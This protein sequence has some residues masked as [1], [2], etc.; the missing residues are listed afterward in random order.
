MQVRAL[1]ETLVLGNT[2][3]AQE[4]VRLGNSGQISQDPTAVKDT[5]AGKHGVAGARDGLSG[6][7]W[8]Q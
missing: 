3:L 4:T 6:K 8:S 2:V 7:L 5:S 1:V